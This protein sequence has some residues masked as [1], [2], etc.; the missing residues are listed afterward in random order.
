MYKMAEKKFDRSA[1]LTKRHLI[2][3]QQR[4]E[5]LKATGDIKPHSEFMR[6]D[7]PFKDLIVAWE[8]SYQ[9]TYTPKNKTL[10]SISKSDTFIVYGVRSP[11]FEDNI[12]LNTTEAVQNMKG[13]SGAGFSTPTQQM[14]G[15]EL[16]VTPDET[17]MPR[18]M[19]LKDKLDLNREIIENVASKGIYLE[20][21]DQDATVKN[22]KGTE[23]KMKTD[24]TTYFK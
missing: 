21:V 12:V 13:K 20:T 23:A 1:F 18:G 2:A 22:K 3:R 16:K 6:T 24:L 11:Q 5:Y 17:R 9:L 10:M 14:I 7:T 19:E 4:A 15:R 8:V